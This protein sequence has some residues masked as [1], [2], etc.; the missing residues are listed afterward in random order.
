V[1]QGR[2]EPCIHIVSMTTLLRA[3][4]AALF[5]LA[6]SGCRGPTFGTTTT[7][8]ATIPTTALSDGATCLRS[9]ACR[10]GFFDQPMGFCALPGVCRA[11]IPCSSYGRA[12]FQATP[13]EGGACMRAGIETSGPGACLRNLEETRTKPPRI[14]PQ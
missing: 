8:S 4:G 9:S 7:T 2:H 6:A 12:G 13:S 14:L 5:L 10:S 11:L 3:A 1:R